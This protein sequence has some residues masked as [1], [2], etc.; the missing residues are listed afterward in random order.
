MLKR[1]TYIRSFFLLATL[2]VLMVS[3]C[4]QASTPQNPQPIEIKSVV[5]PLQP[6]NPGGPIVEITLKN[7]SI[8]PVVSLNAILELGHGPFNFNFDVTPSNPLMPNKSISAKKTL[9]GGIGGGLSG[10]I[11][12]SL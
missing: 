5:G 6:I 2:A 7:V 1:S 12:H 8:E 9:I 3:G 4:G 10:N 11:C